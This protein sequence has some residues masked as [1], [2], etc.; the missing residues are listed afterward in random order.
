MKSN[1]WPEVVS[2]FGI[3]LGIGAAFGLLFAPKSGEETREYLSDTAQSAADEVMDRGKKISRRA[4][5][6][7][8]DAGD[9]V[10]DA[11]QAGEQAFRDAR[12]SS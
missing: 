10:R 2:A 4:K 3:G 11:T 12:N 6:A 7:V 9:Y 5:K 8:D 1:R